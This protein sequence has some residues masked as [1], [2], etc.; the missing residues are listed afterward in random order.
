VDTAAADNDCAV[1]LTWGYAIMS[2]GG[3][4]V[5]AD[6]NKPPEPEPIDNVELTDEDLE[7]VVGGLSAEAS[8]AYVTFLQEASTRNDPAKRLDRLRR[9]RVL[10]T[11]W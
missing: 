9:P 3:F 8:A 1:C 10:L 5:M 7:M 6:T 2:V 4:E 11:D